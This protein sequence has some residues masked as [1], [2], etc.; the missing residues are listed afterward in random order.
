MLES[1]IFN[2]SIKW[3][4][5]PEWKTICGEGLCLL[6]E[7]LIVA[8]SMKCKMYPFCTFWQGSFF[9]LQMRPCR[10]PSKVFY[11]ACLIMMWYWYLF[12]ILFIWRNWG[13][14]HLSKSVYDISFRR[15]VFLWIGL[16][17]W[18]LKLFLFHLM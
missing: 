3:G 2:I 1:A 13:R 17:D 12:L 5:S 9:P 4:C 8:Q 10:Y 18:L 16:P 15:R 6:G 11:F 7:L 14:P